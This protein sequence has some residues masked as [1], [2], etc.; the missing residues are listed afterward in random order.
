ML[1]SSCVYESIFLAKTMEIQRRL[2][3]K[4]PFGI[5]ETFILDC[6]H[7]EIWGDRGDYRWRF[8]GMYYPSKSDGKTYSN[9]GAALEAAKAYLGI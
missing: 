7:I 2:I 4:T 1:L 5:Q 9:S 6:G 3:E 8:T